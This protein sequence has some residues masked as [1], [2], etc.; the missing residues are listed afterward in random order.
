MKVKNVS[1]G[2]TAVKTKFGIILIPAGETKELQE[3]SLLTRL[4]SSLVILKDDDKE[5]VEA[6]TAEDT[7]TADAT[8]ADTTASDTTVADTT[9]EPELSASELPAPEL[10]A[11]ELSTGTSD[12]TD[13]PIT[14]GD[15]PTKEKLQTK[16][17]SLKSS[18]KRTRRVAAKEQI[19][20]EIKE[21]EKQLETMK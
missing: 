15:A 14:A 9:T 1:D 7:V 17:K 12:N 11:P 19:A 21:L 18:W 13:A 8:V 16:L 4:H 5:P 2:T 20:K 3:G 10:P 6:D